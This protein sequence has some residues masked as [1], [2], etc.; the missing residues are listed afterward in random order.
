MFMGRLME[1]PNDIMIY[2]RAIGLRHVEGRAEA[3]ADEIKRRTW[4]ET[5]PIYVR[6]HHAEFIAGT[7]KDGVSLSTL[8]D[9]LQS[10]SFL[11]TQK[12]ARKGNGNTDARSAYRQQAAVQLTNEAFAW[13]NYRL[14]LA[15]AKHGKLTPAE[16]ET[17]DWPTT[18]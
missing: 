14:E 2:G 16:L 4:K 17:L 1:N 6:V 18:H 5:W 10:D 3:S 8:M 12:N 15:F 13:L 9:E 11:P 7:L